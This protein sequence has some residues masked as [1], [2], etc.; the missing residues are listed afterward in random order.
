MTPTLGDASEL[1][2]NGRRTYVVDGERIAVFD[3]DGEFYAIRDACPHVGGPPGDGRVCRR[4]ARA[5]PFVSA[6][7][8]FAPGADPVRT[9]A[10]A[11]DESDRLTISCPVHG[12]EFDLA[13]G[14][15]R[16]PAKRG[17]RTYPVRVEDGLL[18][19]ELKREEPAPDR[20]ARDGSV[21]P[22]FGAP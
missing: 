18:E 1:P 20:E 17:T 22:A 7:R 3:V 2:R 4:P 16:F 14:T 5:A 6:F 19:I 11:T 10:M 8:D 13:D 9:P 21:S 12:W 15:P